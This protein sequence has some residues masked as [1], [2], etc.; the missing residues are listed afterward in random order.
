ML[1][2]GEYLPL[3]Y[4]F[5]AH[6]LFSGLNWVVN[7]E[8]IYFLAT[9]VYKKLI[10]AIV[11]VSETKQFNRRMNFSSV[12]KGLPNDRPAIFFSPQFYPMGFVSQFAPV[13][14]SAW[15]PLGGLEALTVSA[16]RKGHLHTANRSVQ[17]LEKRNKYSY[18]Y[19][20]VS[21]KCVCN[22]YQYGILK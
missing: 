14:F 22:V 18:I 12:W 9:G 16:A 7:I 15:R 21:Y 17:C 6:T 19:L 1:F 4:T 11:T 13:W 10:Y 5:E 8:F 20:Y 3:M 2:V